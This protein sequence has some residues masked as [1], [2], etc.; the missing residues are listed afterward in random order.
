[1]TKWTLIL[2]LVGG[3]TACKSAKKDAAKLN[4]IL[5]GYDSIACYY[6]N[7]DEMTELRY[8]KITDS[9][10]MDTIVMNAKE[11]KPGL[12]ALKPGTGGGV[13]GNWQFVDA[14]FKTNNFNSRTIDT[15]DE[16]EQKFFNTTSVI[17]FLKE[18][19]QP[20]K[21]FLPRKKSD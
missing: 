17:S 8:G 2:I 14:L 20:L 3:V 18:R 19:E 9:L 13:L 11:R 1:M 7:S 10:F 6:G 12:I 16:K 4:I 21:L 5:F 15:L